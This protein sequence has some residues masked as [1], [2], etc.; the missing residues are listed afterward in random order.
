MW[1]GPCSTVKVWDIPNLFQASSGTA[2]G[3]PASG[4]AALRPVCLHTLRTNQQYATEVLGLPSGDIV[5]GSGN[6]SLNVYSK[7][8]VWRCKLDL[9]HER[10]R[11]WL[12]HGCVCV[13]VRC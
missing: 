11:F 9:A 2:S 12:C 1:L 8:G 7:D 5:T 6:K 13:C 4:S 3:A 10:M